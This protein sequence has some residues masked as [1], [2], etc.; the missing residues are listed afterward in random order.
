MFGFGKKKHED[1][2]KKKSH[3]DKLMMGAIVGGAVGSV[4]GMSIAPKKG[5]ETREML[6]QKGKDIIQKGQEVSHKVK[7]QISH[8]SQTTTTIMTEF[9]ELTRNQS[10][11]QSQPA[12]KPGI[13]GKLFGRKNKSAAFKDDFQ[14]IPN[15][16][17]WK[18]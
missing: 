15:E 5:K 1:Q 11:A 18:I 10:T 14:K 17:E 3:I 12:K 16:S 7:E 6:A 2:N 8:A 13:L 4:I 9:P